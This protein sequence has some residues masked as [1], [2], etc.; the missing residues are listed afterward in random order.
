LINYNASPKIIDANFQDA[1]GS[2][3]LSVW[4]MKA[5]NAFSMQKNSQVS[6]QLPDLQHQK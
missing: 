6:D 2:V 3:T 1:A 4:P 5:T